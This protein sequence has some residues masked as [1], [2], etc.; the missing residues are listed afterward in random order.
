MLPSNVSESLLQDIKEKMNEVEFY[1]SLSDFLHK[2]FPKIKFKFVKTIEQSDQKCF[3]LQ[4][5]VYEFYKNHEYIGELAICEVG[6]IKNQ[7]MTVE[8]CNY[9][10]IAKNV[11]YVFTWIYKIV[12]DED[13][14]N[15]KREVKK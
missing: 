5:N 9:A 15:K 4:T 11:E 1:G 2:Y 6:I 13:N 3:I 14:N 10:L 12:S 8:D 7:D